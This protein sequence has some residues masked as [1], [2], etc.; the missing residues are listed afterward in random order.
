MSTAHSE[1]LS[2]EIL[3]TD[4][5]LLESIPAQVTAALA[6]DLG[7][8]INAD[9]DVTASLIPEQQQA[10]A[11]LITREAGVLCGVAWV[12]EVFR[13]LGDNVTIE[14]HAADGDPVQP[15]QLLCSLNGSARAL[16]TGERTAM[17]F[18]QT[19][20]A[21]ATA[22]ASAVKHL[23]STNTELLDT[24][25]TIPGLRLA[26]K[27]AVRCGGG[28]NHRIG[29]FDAF[30][31]KENHIAACGSISQAITSARQNYPGRWLEIETESLAELELALAAGADVIML[32]NFSLDDIRTAVEL[33]RGQAKLEVSG[34]VTSD[35]FAMYAA[36]GVD[37]ISSGALTKHVRAMDLSMRI[38]TLL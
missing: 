4:T 16:L 30:L 31:I 33:T 6:E 2:I 3:G 26:Q 38:T 37:Y 20:S 28:S 29:L 32:D 13:Q 27:Y 22:V 24:R 34:N 12:N 18:L 1:P 14:W 23:Q 25:K 35:Q 36:T 19:L 7:G 11:R 15:N 5:A 10:S 9:A 8:E 17:N 21:T